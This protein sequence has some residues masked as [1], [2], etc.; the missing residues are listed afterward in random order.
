MKN[1]IKS[2]YTCIFS[3]LLAVVIILCWLAN[4]LFLSKF[5]IARKKTILQQTYDVIDYCAS[6][7]GYASDE[8]KRVFENASAKNN[9]DILV[10]DTDM[11]VIASNMTDD[12]EI[13]NLLLAHFFGTDNNTKIF[14][15]SSDYTI[16]RTKDPNLDSEFIELWGMISTTNLIVIRTPVSGIKDSAEISNI[17]LMY[18]GFLT[19]CIS[20]VA[21]YVISKTITDPI[22]QL[23]SLAD[24]MANLDFTA[25]YKGDDDTEVGMLGE[26]MNK[27]S[28]TLE[29]TISELKTANNELKIDL[30]KRNELDDMRREFVSNV[31]HELKTPIALIQ[32]YAEGLKDCVNDDEESRDFYCSVILDEADKMN[33]LVK[34][35]LKLNELEYGQ[36]SAVL[37]RFDIVEVIR[38]CIYNF[39][40]MINQEK[41]DVEL[42]YF[43]PIYVWSDEFMIETVLN[44]YISNAIHYVKEDSNG[45]KKIV[46]SI[47]KISENNDKKIRVCVYNTG[48]A[49]PEEALPQ[50]WTKFYKVDK[51]RTREYGGS[52][53]GLS[54]VKASME[55]LNQEYGVDNDENG[56]TFWFEVDGRVV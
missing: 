52:G 11:N 38:N 3:I 35:L 44:N 6:S 9:F 8:F 13:A 4:I 7:Y 2:K 55:A 18:I 54:I 32:G 36:N 15:S 27:M 50:L 25:K 12:Q 53:I 51:A 23:V 17:F 29:K 19:I 56:V 43:E 39:E 42:A 40:I 16:S 26:H 33:N 24:R 1:S 41:I 28:E 47:K 46:I 48:D 30:E 45:E 31:S 20:I 14:Y 5:Y 10:L 22:L 49:I 21:V 37:E 34:N